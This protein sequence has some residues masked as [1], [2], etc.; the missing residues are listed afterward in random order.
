[1]IRFVLWWRL[2]T[3]FG[4]SVTGTEGT[5]ESGTEEGKQKWKLSNIHLF[6][7]IWDVALIEGQHQETVPGSHLGGVVTQTR[8]EVKNNNSSENVLTRRILD[9]GLRITRRLEMTS[10]TQNF[11]IRH[12]RV[13]TSS[14]KTKISTYLVE[15]EQ[16]DCTCTVLTQ[17]VHCLIVTAGLSR[18][19]FTV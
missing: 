15:E 1:M 19:G 14:H 2:R 16:V 17:H 3:C 7:T 8:T 13:V 9:Y 10:L 4:T 6:D 12:D 5:E 11:K 18:G